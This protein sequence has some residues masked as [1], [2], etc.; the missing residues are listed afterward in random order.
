VRQ[1]CC[2]LV[3]HALS[4]F[5]SV[6]SGL[7]FWD[8]VRNHLQGSDKTR[9]NSMQVPC[10]V[11]SD[12]LPNV[13][14][15][16]KSFGCTARSER[17]GGHG[18]HPDRPHRLDDLVLFQPVHRLHNGALCGNA[19]VSRCFPIPLRDDS[20]LWGLYEQLDIGCIGLF[21][22]KCLLNAASISV[23]QSA[24]AGILE[25]KRHEVPVASY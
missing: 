25:N 21:V 3:L 19:P 4:H 12:R 18:W 20:S 2:N 10:L 9:M 13:S 1:S 7:D 17:V 6:L 22:A 15:S 8:R 5:C 14:L 24:H 11:C 16:T 23:Q